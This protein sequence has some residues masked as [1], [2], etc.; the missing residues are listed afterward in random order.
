MIYFFAALCVGECRAARVFDC[1]SCLFFLKWAAGSLSCFEY[2]MYR[3][4]VCVSAWM[5]EWEKER[6]RDQGGQTYKVPGKIFLNIY[7][8]S[9]AYETTQVIAH[10][11]INPHSHSF[12]E[13]LTY[14]IIPFHLSHS[15][16][17]HPPPLSSRKW[18]TVNF[19][20]L[21][22][23]LPSGSKRVGSTF[24]SVCVRYSSGKMDLLTPL[25]SLLSHEEETNCLYHQHKS[26][27]HTQN[28][29]TNTSTHA[30]SRAHS[31]I[32]SHVWVRYTWYITRPIF[33]KQF[34]FLVKF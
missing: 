16:P 11:Y 20:L 5:C 29:D 32:N 24:V 28:T 33:T 27:L 19:Q 15:S 14:S 23:S 3:S 17:L 26:N 12:T 31:C 13:S 34:Q 7:L 4:K 6:E 22:L 18:N 9:L 10:S 2:T 21:F 30:L 8:C 1:F 25:C